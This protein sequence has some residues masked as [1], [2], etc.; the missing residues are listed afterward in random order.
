[1]L[2][3]PIEGSLDNNTGFYKSSDVRM[4]KH[5]SIFWPQKLEQD[6]GM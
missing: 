2:F 6:L 1:M 4:K 3:F 5:D